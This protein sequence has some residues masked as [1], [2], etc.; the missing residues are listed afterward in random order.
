MT[1]ELQWKEEKMR[2][3]NWDGAI[4]I[5]LSLAPSSLSSPTMPSTVHRLVNRQTY[6]HVGL[7]HAV[8]RFQQF[9]P[10]GPV[11]DEDIEGNDENGCKV[12]NFRN[13]DDDVVIPLCWFEDEKTGKPLRWH[14]F[15]GPLYDLLRL[16]SEDISLPW[17]IRVHFTSYPASSLLPLSREEPLLKILSRTYSASL[18]QALYIQHG[19]NKVAMS[20]TRRDHACIWDAVVRGSWVLYAEVNIAI[21]V[22]SKSYPK[23]LPIR[24][25]VDG[26]PAIARPCH[27]FR[28]AV[29]TTNCTENDKKVVI[30]IDKD[31]CKNTKMNVDLDEDTHIDEETYKV[32]NDKNAPPTGNIG[33]FQSRDCCDMAKM[34][35][36]DVLKEWLPHL[37]PQNGEQTYHRDSCDL[38]KEI[39]KD[40]QAFEKEPK[41][42]IQGIKIPWDYPIL[43]LW[44]CLCH[45]DHFLYITVVTFK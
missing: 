9:A 41:W 36:G 33:Q 3:T 1:E 32:E 28:R 8:K 29:D 24:L 16:S 12:K 7:R 11:D 37:F 27:P 21:Q 14:L 45:P 34:T 18:K 23:C 39:K 44:S 5:A 22:T 30:K 17:A 26:R 6:L 10:I 40:G 15:V 35:I 43:D 19:T 38:E 13:E 20:M 42:C 4:P 2:R 31:P 25:L